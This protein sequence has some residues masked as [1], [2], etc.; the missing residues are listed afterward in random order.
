MGGC[1]A[2]ELFSCLVFR[3]SL[4]FPL[5]FFVDQFIKKAVDAVCLLLL[6]SPELLVGLRV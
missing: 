4:L 3:F 2:G 5:G 6:Q 1:V